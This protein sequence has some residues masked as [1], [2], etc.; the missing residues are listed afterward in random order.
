MDTD[1]VAQAQQGDKDAFAVLVG[2]RVDR[3]LAIANRILRDLS[4]AEEA[5][6]QT[7]LDLWRD[8]PQLRDPAR[9]DAWS[10]RV[11]VRACYA[12]ARQSR[13]WASNIRLLPA[14][15]QAAVDPTSDILNRDELERAFRRL[16]LDHRTVIVLHH[17]LELSHPEA[18]E[19]LGVS[20][21]TV[22]SRLHYALRGLR[23]AL[24]ADTRAPR[25]EVAQ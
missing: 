8:L 3:Y 6:Q 20:A 12:E 17:Y 13:R 2:A 1:L 10:Y 23:A 21:G 19:I 16:S 7:L 18:A 25:T 5:T 24:E 9:F 4:L 15:E 11:L 22:A 14:D